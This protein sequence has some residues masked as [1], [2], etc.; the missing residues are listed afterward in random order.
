M[1]AVYLFLRKTA[2]SSLAQNLR[3]FDKIGAV[4]QKRWN[5][6]GVLCMVGVS[7]AVAIKSNI[8]C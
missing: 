7:F 2:V 3:E 1:R 6:H 4:M 8:D 5:G